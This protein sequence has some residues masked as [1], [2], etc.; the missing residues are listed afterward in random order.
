MLT[1]TMVLG[2][3]PGYHLFGGLLLLGHKHH[4]KSIRESELPE[5]EL[6]QLK[7][8]LGFGTAVFV[9]ITHCLNRSI[10]LNNNQ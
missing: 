3:D 5:L 4:S 1:R 7:G 6:E 9:L 10:N 8:L 2:K